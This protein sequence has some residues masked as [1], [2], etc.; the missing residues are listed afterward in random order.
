MHAPKESPL[1]W[2]C[3]HHLRQ[4]CQIYIPA[5]A[6]SLDFRCAIPGRPPAVLPPLATSCPPAVSPVPPNRHLSPSAPLRTCCLGHQ[7]RTTRMWTDGDIKCSLAPQQ[8]TTGPGTGTA[9]RARRASRVLGTWKG[10][11]SYVMP[12]P[13]PRDPQSLGTEDAFPRGRS[14][15]RM[16]TG[17][18]LSPRSSQPWALQEGRVAG[19]LEHGFPRPPLHSVLGFL[20]LL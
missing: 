16:L 5:S 9:Q 10:S 18:P 11:R 14:P 3:W 17:V 7:A 4:C 19:L 12:W 6:S 15:A 8:P 2:G 20:L 1:P 13:R